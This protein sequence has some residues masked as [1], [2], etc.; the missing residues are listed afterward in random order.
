MATEIKYSNIAASCQARQHNGNVYNTNTNY[1]Y[2]QSVDQAAREALN[3]AFRKA[4]AERQ[5]ERMRVLL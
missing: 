5:H 3:K 2:Q 1:T 4:A